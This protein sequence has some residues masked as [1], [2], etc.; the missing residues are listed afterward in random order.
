MIARMVAAGVPKEKA[1]AMT[2]N[3][4]YNKE[5]YSDYE[6]VASYL[7]EYNF[8]ETLEDADRI[9]ENMSDK[10]IS[11]I[12][13]EA[14]PAHLQAPTLADINARQRKDAEKNRAQAATQSGW[15]DR[16]GKTEGPLITKHPTKDAAAILHA[17][18]QRPHRTGNPSRISS[19]MNPER[20]QAAVADITSGAPLS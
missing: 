16:T 13:D 9:I 14:M 3:K 10:W 5:E 12:L 6:I 4:S 2:K 7:L 11:Q 20:R 1:I 15:K 18:R 19:F 17:T 8:A